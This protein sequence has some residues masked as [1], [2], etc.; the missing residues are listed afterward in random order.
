MRTLLVMATA[1]FLISQVGRAQPATSKATP[2]VS[3]GPECFAHMDTPEFPKTALE[4]K[5]DGSVWTW[6]KVT[7]EGKASQIQTQVVSAWSQGPKLLTPPVEA[8]LKA[9]TFK[10]E[11]A[12]KDVS[13][14]FRYEVHGNPVT[15]PK[16]T[17]K[18]D[19]NI[20]YLESEPET[21]T[22]ASAG[23]KAQH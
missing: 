16:V 5:I 10:P 11:C 17:S 22:S 6:L 13:V 15:H 9:S 21:V 1:S 7:P 18:T 23:T 3:A 8:A 14:V 2:T 19:G 20:V 4:E 12:G